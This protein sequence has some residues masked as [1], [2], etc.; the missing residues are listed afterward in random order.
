[1]KLKG[2]KRTKTERGSRRK[3]NGEE[4]NKN[5]EKPTPTHGQQPIKEERRFNGK[6]LKIIPVMGLFFVFFVKI[7]S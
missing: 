6:K 4:K 7:G 3:H 1:M 5:K 2:R